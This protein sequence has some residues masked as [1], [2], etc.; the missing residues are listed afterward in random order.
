MNPCRWVHSYTAG[1]TTTC[2]LHSVCADGTYCC[3]GGT[4]RQINGSSSYSSKLLF[5]TANQAAASSVGAAVAAAAT[6]DAA[7]NA[8]RPPRSAKRQGPYT[9]QQ[10]LPAKRQTTQQRQHAGTVQRSRGRSSATS[11]SSAAGL[12]SEL[13]SEAGALNEQQLQQ[14]LSLMHRKKQSLQ[15]MLHKVHQQR[16]QLDFAM[17]LAYA[18]QRYCH[19]REGRKIINA[20]TA[21]DSRLL[22]VFLRALCSCDAQTAAAAAQVVSAVSSAKAVAESLVQAVLAVDGGVELLGQALVDQ[23]GAT[24][25]FSSSK[26]YCLTN[27][28]YEAP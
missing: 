26:E 17:L 5:N 10:Q 3:R 20:L 24:A 14:L 2:L 6:A 8:G 21:N 9:L 25:N 13:P 7:G 27:F 28:L 18:A 16:G 11:S 23:A 22:P 12:L 15:D 19:K 4:D 1:I